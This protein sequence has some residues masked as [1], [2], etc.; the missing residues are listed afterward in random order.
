MGLMVE[1]FCNGLSLGVK[2]GSKCEVQIKRQSKEWYQPTS[3][4][5]KEV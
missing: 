2:H 5:K 4:Q 1:A 3:P